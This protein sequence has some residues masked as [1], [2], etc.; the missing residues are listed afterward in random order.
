MFPNQEIQKMEKLFC[1]YN[2]LKVE[3]QH[4]KI[5]V[6]DLLLV[7][8]LRW[9][10]KKSYC[11]EKL[12]FSLSERFQRLMDGSIVTQRKLFLVLTTYFL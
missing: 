1:R 5:P 10:K 3:K 8:M 7:Q 12:V 4:A 6:V 11:L 9:K 2:F